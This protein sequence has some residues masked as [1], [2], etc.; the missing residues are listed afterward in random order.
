MNNK[1]NQISLT[2]SNAFL[3]LDVSFWFH[4]LNLFST[5]K[6]QQFKA[7][8][9]YNLDNFAKKSWDNVVLV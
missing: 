9:H 7:P 5:E 8:T 4:V 2:D 3:R 6:L 1:K